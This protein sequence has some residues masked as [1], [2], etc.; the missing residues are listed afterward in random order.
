MH[1]CGYAPTRREWMWAS[2]WTAAAAFAAGCASRPEIEGRTA[3]AAAPGGAAQLAAANESGASRPAAS[4]ES[5]AAAKA[6]LREHVSIDVHTHAGP[7]GIHS[8]PA[9]PSAPPSH[10]P[11]RS[12]RTGAI[13]VLCPADVPDGPILGRDASN[14]LRAVRTPEPGFLYRYH[15]ERLD[16][17]DILCAKHGI[18]R[19]VTVEDLTA[20]H[21]AGAP[22]VI[23]DIEGLDFLEK[24]LERLEESYRR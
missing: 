20:A 12:M 1:C 21:K 15:L 22:A 5:S 18:R 2:L 14:V 23:V 13:A 4:A 19:V 11:A 7:D 6:L 10:D 16:W 8:R 3:S 9:P 24:K 17:V